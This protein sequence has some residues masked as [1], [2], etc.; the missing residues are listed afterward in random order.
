MI[1]D[2]TAFLDKMDGH[3][4]VS[5]VYAHFGLDFGVGLAV[6]GANSRTGAVAHSAGRARIDSEK[7]A[8]G[9]KAVCKA[10]KA[11]PRLW[12]LG[13]LGHAA[14]QGYRAPALPRLEGRYHA[15]FPA[16]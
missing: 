11:P 15:S 3:Q 1:D 9:Q 10:R 5:L 7:F 16:R 4:C 6:A 8:L 2:G 12:Q 14:Q 13:Q